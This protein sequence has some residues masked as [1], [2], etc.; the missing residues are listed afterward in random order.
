MIPHAYPLTR[1]GDPP[2]STVPSIGASD[3]ALEVV[4]GL[5]PRV[6]RAPSPTHLLSATVTAMT[7]ASATASLAAVTTTAGSQ[8]SQDTRAIAGAGP[9]HLLTNDEDPNSGAV[10]TQ[11]ISTAKLKGLKE[12]GQDATA[13]ALV[14]VCSSRR[15]RDLDQGSVEPAVGACSLSLFR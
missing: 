6:V 1:E 8:I 3:S 2:I 14:L 7:D 10:R 9:L 15:G 12:P 13:V 11:P 5:L 4:A